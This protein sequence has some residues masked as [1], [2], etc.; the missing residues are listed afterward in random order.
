MFG[1]F[2]TFC[3][4]IRWPLLLIIEIPYTEEFRNDFN[5]KTPSQ[6]FQWIASRPGPCIHQLLWLLLLSLHSWPL[7]IDSICQGSELSLSIWCRIFNA[8]LVLGIGSAVINLEINSNKERAATL[9][10]QEVCRQQW[11]SIETSCQASKLH[12]FKLY[13]PTELLKKLINTQIRDFSNMPLDPFPK[14]TEIQKSFQVQI[15][16]QLVESENRSYFPWLLLQSQQCDLLQSCTVAVAFVQVLCVISRLR[17]PTV[18]VLLLSAGPIWWQVTA[19]DRSWAP[20]VFCCCSIDDN[21]E[22]S[23]WFKVISSSGKTCPDWASTNPRL[24]L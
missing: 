13:R 6:V 17:L 3:G 19:R 5:G 8:A 10:I 9:S 7:R 20:I 14:F 15:L 4:S 21:D 24:H 12:Q 23:L 22:P 11:P 2:L 16:C 1:A 18:L